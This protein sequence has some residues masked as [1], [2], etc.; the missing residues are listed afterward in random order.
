MVGVDGDEREVALH[1][2]VRLADRLDE[3][4]GVV[5]LDQV[6]DGLGV[7]LRRE[8]VALGLEARLRARGSSRR[9]R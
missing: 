2:V 9:C 6:R 4:A 1:L 3:V 5:A 7:G 8:D